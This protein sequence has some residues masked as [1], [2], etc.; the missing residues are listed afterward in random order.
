MAK[1]K[2]NHTPHMN[3]TVNSFLLLGPAIGP[4]G[5]EVAG[6]PSPMAPYSPHLDEHHQQTWA[7]HA[8]TKCSTQKCG[9]DVMPSPPTAS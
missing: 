8:G 5:L 1:N 4:A 3:F 6:D 9:T 2:E 7:D